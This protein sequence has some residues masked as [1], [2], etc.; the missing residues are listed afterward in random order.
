MIFYRIFNQLR[1]NNFNKLKNL[2]RFINN[3]NMSDEFKIKKK[4]SYIEKMNK[5]TRKRR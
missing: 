3:S 4:K 5:E 2:I 1:R